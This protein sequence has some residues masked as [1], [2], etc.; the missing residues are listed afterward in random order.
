MLI[1]FSIVNVGGN[2]IANYDHEIS[3][4]ST[5]E[6]DMDLMV[7]QFLSSFAI[8]FLQK[9]MLNKQFESQVT[10]EQLTKIVR[11]TLSTWI[12]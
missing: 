3:K 12:K 2:A 6:L 1:Q 8:I 9:V 11:Y 7:N 5:K 10:D 4:F